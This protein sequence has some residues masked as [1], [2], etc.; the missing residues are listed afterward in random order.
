MSVNVA[1]D[2][3]V[4]IRGNSVILELDFWSVSDVSLKIDGR[5][6]APWTISVKIC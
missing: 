3:Y 2:Y 1:P 4:F 6:S 5:N